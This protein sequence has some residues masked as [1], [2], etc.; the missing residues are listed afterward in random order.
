MS[1]ARALLSGPGRCAALYPYNAARP[2]RRWLG[3]GSVRRSAA[4]AIDSD[5]PATRRRAKRQWPQLDAPLVSTG[6]RK[7]AGLHRG[8]PSSRA[9]GLESPLESR[10][11]AAGKIGS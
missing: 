11:K 2:A 6:E 5:T 1:T 10:P 4:L 9:K 8:R 3:T 7:P